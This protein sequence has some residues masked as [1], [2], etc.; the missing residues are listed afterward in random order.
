[1]V[2]GAAAVPRRPPPSPAVPRRRQPSALRSPRRPLGGRRFASGGCGGRSAFC[3]RRV[4]SGAVGCRRVPSAEGGLEVYICN[5]LG[6]G[7][8]LEV[9]ICNYGI[10]ICNRLAVMVG[11]QPDPHEVLWGFS[12][13][14]RFGSVGLDG[15]LSARR[16]GRALRSMWVKCGARRP[17]PSSRH[18]G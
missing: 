18:V 3:R 9:Y 6:V 2:F 16:A 7:V 11:R 15:L 14:P 13:L 5:R 8:G 4:P 12:P 17:P 10:Y 1:M